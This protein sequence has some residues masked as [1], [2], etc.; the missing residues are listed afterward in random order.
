MDEL[1]NTSKEKTDSQNEIKQEEKENQQVKKERKE[2]KRDET[3]E[4]KQEEDEKEEDNSKKRSKLSLEGAKTPISLYTRRVMDISKINNY[5]T[6]SSTKGR[7]G[8]HNLGNTCFMNSSIACI[9][10]CTELTYYFLKGD[11]KKDINENNKLGMQGELAKSWGNLLHEYWVENT[12]VGNPRNF[13]N[14]IGM[15]A[16]KFR[17]YSQ[18]DSNEFMSIFLDYL[19]EDLNRTTKKEY[20]EL[21]EKQENETDEECAKRFWECNLKRNDSIIT[22]LFCG[23]FKSTIT[24]PNCGRINI[25]FDPFDAINLPMAKKNKY[26]K[27]VFD[28]FKIF[29]VP[30][31]CLRDMVC[32]RIKN[33]DKY[34]YIDNVIERIKKEKNFVYHDKIDK[35]LVVDVFKKNK[36]GYITSMKKIDS[37]NYKN[38]NVFCFDIMDKNDDKKLPIYF[39][40]N[41]SKSQYPRIIFGNNKMTL[42]DLRKKIYINLRKYILS[43]L[44]K[45][46]EEKDSLSLEFEKYS[47]DEELELNDESLLDLIE[48]EYQ[49]LFNSTTEE[50]EEEDAKEEK[51]EN[52]V[53]KEKDGDEK[54]IEM[55][56]K[57][58]PFKIYLG[59]DSSPNEII[60]VDEEYF[61][62]LSPQF[63]HFSKLNSFKES[64]NNS[65]LFEKI[66]K[67]YKMYVEFNIDSKYINKDINKET[68]KDTNKDTD[69]DTKEDTNKS[70]N[71]DDKINLD[72]CRVL[73]LEY[74]IKEEETNEEEEEDNGKLTLEKCLKKFT[75][76]EKLEEGNEWYCSK[77]KNHVLAKKKL[78]FFYLPKILIICFKRFVKESYRWEKNGDYVEFPIDNMDLKDFVIGPDKEHSKYD[79]FA[80]SQHY[81]STGFGHYTAVCKNDGKW[82]SYDDSSCSP[83]KASSC[84][85]SA[86]YV[87]FYRRQTD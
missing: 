86:A 49:K 15:K 27:T 80:V 48:K 56:R 24:C 31:Y 14:T 42:D 53:E 16:V 38:E 12:K 2:E 62:K 39:L 11:Y 41:N 67:N 36:Y 68:N 7:C 35:L 25:T 55:F 37:Y 46:N 54:Y 28:E 47:K 75:K 57:D 63:K 1:K 79:L 85:T 60:F 82:F 78:E 45:E 72:Y 70:T 6:E 30:K 18:H 21:K 44:L 32:L 61:T 40:A 59:R 71:K 34:E 4:E 83:T 20:I 29:Y 77:C 74:E 69:E 9:S 3:E 13:K 8:G 51:K 87:L 50:E 64:L 10:N 76:E 22:D 5:L 58:M 81:G 66:D 73:S 65:N 19:S 84:Q 33:I 23:Q 52:K 26:E 43:P 17:G